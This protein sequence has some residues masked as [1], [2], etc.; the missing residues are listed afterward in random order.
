MGFAFDQGRHSPYLL[1]SM[2]RRTL[3]AATLAWPSVALA[4]STKAGD[5]GIGHAWALPS[6]NLDGQV[7]FAILNK[8]KTTDALIAARS[9]ICSTI[10]LRRNARYDDPAEAKFDLLPMKPL[11]MRPSAV[12]LR[13]IGLRQPLVLGGRFSLTLDFLN[14]GEVEVEVY[15][16]D[17]P[18]E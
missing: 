18:G 5:I 11:P 15:V 16:E 3:I 17:T 2:N 1:R 9:E 12:H 7:F 14:A 13:L 4:H 10:E 8:G 6:Q